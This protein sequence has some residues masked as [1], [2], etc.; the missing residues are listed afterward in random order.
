MNI[1]PARRHALMRI[2]LTLSAVLLLQPAVS[3]A[4]AV[5]AKLVTRVFTVTHAPVATLLITAGSPGHTLGDLRVLPATPILDTTG[6]E[7]GRLDAQL[8]TTS[9]DYPTA[10]DEVRMTTLN[11]VFGEGTQDLSGSADQLVVS[12]SGYYPGTSSTI[13]TGTTLIRPITGGSGK[14]SGAGGWAESE[15]LLDGSWRHTFHLRRVV[16]R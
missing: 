16:R 7:V 15:H 14:F 10:G 1:Q 8:L 6:A 11:F 13:A 3:E 2:A 5:A 12:G 4:Q 9:I